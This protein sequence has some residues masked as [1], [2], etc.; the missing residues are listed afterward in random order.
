MSTPAIVHETFA[1]ERT[2]PT[3]AAR[4]FGAFADPV[5]KRRWFVEGEGW[6]IDE[7]NV[8]FRVGGHES[9]RFR[10]EGGPS[11]TNE[12]IYHDIVPDERIVFS[13]VMTVSSKR[14]SVSL[15]SVELF[16]S[17]KGTRLVY[18]E[19]G[20]FFDGADLPKQ[21][22]IGCVELLEKLGEELEQTSSEETA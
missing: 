4:V 9:S 6:Q 11:V 20:Q 10:F 8:D 7:F 15:A 21:R 2:Y 19:Q 5:I 14:I 1:I 13:Y 17:G 16:A 18:T 12:T 3:S 22:E